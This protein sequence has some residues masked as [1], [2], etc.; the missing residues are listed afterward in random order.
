MRRHSNYRE[1]MKTRRNEQGAVVAAAIARCRG[2]TEIAVAIHPLAYLLD[3]A[4]SCEGT[5]DAAL[6]R[7]TSPPS[8]RR[9]W[10][11]CGP[12]G[13]YRKGVG[14]RN[15]LLPPLVASYLDA[16]PAAGVDVRIGNTREVA[17]SVARLEVHMGLIE[18]P[19]REAEVRVMPWR[20]D[21]LVI[22]CA[23]THP[24]AQDGAQRVPLKAL[25]QTRSR[26]KRAHCHRPSMGAWKTNRNRNRIKNLQTRAGASTGSAHRQSVHRKRLDPIAHQRPE[27]A[28]HWPLTAG[29][30]RFSVNSNENPAIH[31]AS[32]RGFRRSD[33]SA[34]S[35]CDC[36]H[37]DGTLPLRDSA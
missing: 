10:S 1:L 14:P 12:G 29:Q 5:T 31:D 28:V 6:G 32:T 8:Q 24:L 36:T 4:F 35:R 21:D 37:A 9:G 7:A 13:T 11:R 18:G 15:Y 34:H 33:G 25:R 30:F 3:V 22:V 16:W 20:E 2:A 19:C 23:P 27:P 17:G 26:F